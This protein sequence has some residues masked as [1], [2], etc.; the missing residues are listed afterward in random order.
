[1]GKPINSYKWKGLDVS[2]WQNEQGKSVSIKKSYKQKE[3][4]FK[5]TIYYFPN[6]V[7]ELRRL[8]DEVIQGPLKDELNKDLK[9]EKK[10]S[11][12]DLISDMDNDDPF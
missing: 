6:E 8:L 10:S 5:D 7:V 4:T 2:V 11:Q 12:D 9:E 1:M 3:G